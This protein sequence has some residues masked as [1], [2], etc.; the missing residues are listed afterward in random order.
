M[1]IDILTVVPEL[2]KQAMALYFQLTYIPAPFS[3]Y[4]DVYKLEP[5]HYM[6]LDCKS[7]DFS[8]NKIEFLIIVSLPL[9]FSHDKT[10][11]LLPFFALYSKF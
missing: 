10:T 9:I 4:R 5:N 8:I 3:I 6:T 1:R 11:S 2:S 7:N